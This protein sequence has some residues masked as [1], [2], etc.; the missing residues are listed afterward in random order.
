MHLTGVTFSLS[1]LGATGKWGASINC[2]HILECDRNGC[3]G[4]ERNYA[5]YFL[6]SDF[7]LPVNNK[8]NYLEDEMFGFKDLV[9]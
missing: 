6:E 2:V 8:M 9:L 1:C 7:H 4:T 3:A 5:R